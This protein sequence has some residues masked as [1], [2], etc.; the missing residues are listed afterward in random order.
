MPGS[1]VNDECYLEDDGGQSTYLFAVEA[2][3][4]Q[5][6]RQS[7]WVRVGPVWYDDETTGP[8]VWIEY[9]EQHMGA[10]PMAGPVML[11]PQVWRELAGAVEQRLA[12]FD[13]NAYKPVEPPTCP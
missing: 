9:Q 3:G 6:D 1:T 12:S 11:T 7:L 13:L 10:A 5:G 4:S 8:V 2:A